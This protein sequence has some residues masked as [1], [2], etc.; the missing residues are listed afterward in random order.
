MTD[1]ETLNACCFLI[2]RILKAKAEKVNG[3]DCKYVLEGLGDNDGNYLGNIK[4]EW[5]NDRK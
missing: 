1:D 5:N 3:T 2:A 4:V